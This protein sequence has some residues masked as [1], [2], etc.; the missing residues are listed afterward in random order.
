VRRAHDVPGTLR[1]IEPKRG[2]LSAASG[3]ADAALNPRAAD[4]LPRH[5]TLPDHAG[6]KPYL[7]AQTR[8]GGA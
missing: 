5:P 6:P 1:V 2:A 8:G 7:L 3:M 4:Q